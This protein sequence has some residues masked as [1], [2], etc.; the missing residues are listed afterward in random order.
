MPR[1]RKADPIEIREIKN[2]PQRKPLPKTNIVI[3]KGEITPDDDLCAVALSK[4]YELMQKTHWGQIA[5][6]ADSD[7]LNEYCRLYA[8]KKDA[9]KQT[10]ETGG[11]VLTS[12]DGGNYYN[13]WFT[14]SNRCAADM[15]KIASEFGGTPAA[16]VKLGIFQKKRDDEDDIIKIFN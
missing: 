10:K 16:R 3:E 5:T 11:A 2:N 8:T 4:F 13:M 15:R 7:Q 1:G 9:D 6:S 14:V 12:P